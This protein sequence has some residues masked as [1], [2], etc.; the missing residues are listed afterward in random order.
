VYGS[1]HYKYN[2]FIQN[3]SDSDDDADD[4]YRN[5][6][7]DDMEDDYIH[8]SHSS[9]STHNRFGEPF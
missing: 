9:Q 8:P 1:D 5:P 6:K 7:G 4:I 2:H 3:T